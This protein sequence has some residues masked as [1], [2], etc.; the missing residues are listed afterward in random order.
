[1]LA[2]TAK[3]YTSPAKRTGSTVQ[4]SALVL[5]TK[6][7]WVNVLRAEVTFIPTESVNTFAR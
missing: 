4:G 5:E 1:L 3:K 7:G 6:E 2:K